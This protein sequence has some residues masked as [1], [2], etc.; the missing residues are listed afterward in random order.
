M[1]G[2]GSIATGAGPKSFW[3]VG[4]GLAVVQLS[5]RDHPPA[6]CWPQNPPAR[7]C[8][9]IPHAAPCP[10][11]ETLHPRPP[12]P[13]R[14]SCRSSASSP[15]HCP[16]PHFATSAP[17]SLVIEKVPSWKSACFFLGVRL[18][19]EGWGQGLGRIRRA[20]RV[21]TQPSPAQPSSPAGGQWPRSQRRA[22]M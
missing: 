12:P 19:F 17:S 21:R 11:P 3:L 16:L 7:P 22:A 4:V 20:V 9:L 14:A 15:K 13:H 18:G 8:F 10:A 6:I 5:A 1:R 2:P